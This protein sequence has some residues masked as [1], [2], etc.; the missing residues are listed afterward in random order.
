MIYWE[1]INLNFSDVLPTRAVI[2]NL[3]G[4]RIGADQK[5]INNLKI[6]TRLTEFAEI[7]KIVLISNFVNPTF[8][9]I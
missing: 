3:L 1:I 5:I 2:S 7:A 8:E 6:N 9:K 4:E